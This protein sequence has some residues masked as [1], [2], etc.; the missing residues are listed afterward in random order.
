MYEMQLLKDREKH[1]QKERGQF[2]SVETSL[3]DCLAQPSQ[4]CLSNYRKKLKIVYL[5]RGAITKIRNLD[6]PE[7]WK[8]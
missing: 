1:T 6:S 2:I 7:L 3:P 8:C 5:S 4:W